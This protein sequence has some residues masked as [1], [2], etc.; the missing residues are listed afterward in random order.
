MNWLCACL[1][2]EEEQ[3]SMLCVTPGIVDTG[4]QAEVRDQR[5]F[6]KDGDMS[7]RRPRGPCTLQLTVHG[8]GCR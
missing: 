7:A 4:Q 2:V 1:A 8:V 6:L 3:V 5:E